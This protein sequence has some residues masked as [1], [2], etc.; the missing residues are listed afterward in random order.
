[1]ES[2]EILAWLIAAALLVTVAFAYLHPDRRIGGDVLIIDGDTMQLGE[3]AIRLFGVDAFEGRQ[4]CTRD[5][6][7]WRCGEAATD[8][9]R[10]M[11]EARAITCTKK[12]PTCS[13]VPSPFAPT[14]QWTLAPS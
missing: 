4:I 12:T 6:S 14:A 1:M 13:G 2:R 11:A 5:A 7:P 9:L 8:E 3:T 10:K